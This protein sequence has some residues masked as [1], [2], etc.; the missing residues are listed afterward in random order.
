MVGVLQAGQFIWELS[1]LN[2]AFFKPADV[3]AHI[4]RNDL[5][6]LT[7]AV[8]FNA[9]DRAIFAWNDQPHMIGVVADG[10]AFAQAPVF[11]E[12]RSRGNGNVKRERK[13]LKSPGDFRNMLLARF[14]L[15]QV[16]KVNEL[17]VI[18]NEKVEFVF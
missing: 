16:A 1:F 3:A 10:A 8:L 4:E 14:V 11:V 12:L 5:V 18:E 9:K 2:V 15:C 13:R 7:R 17:D 6:P